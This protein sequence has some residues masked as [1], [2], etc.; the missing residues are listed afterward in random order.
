[1]IAFAFGPYELD[2]D[3]KELRRDGEP[4]PL[5]SRLADVLCALVS[6][7]GQTLTKDQLIQAAWRDVAV[8][9]NSLEQAISSLRRLLGSAAPHQYIDTQARR[10]YRFVAPVTRIE[11]R[12]SDAALE[13]LLA[14]HRAWM[15]GRAALESLERRE[16]VRARAVF[17]DVVAAAP[18]QAPAHVGLANA[19]AMQF[20]MTRAESAPDF[21]A[22]TLAV[23]HAKEA[24]RLDAG[25]GE[26]WATLGFVLERT[27]ERVDALA[28]LRR[29]VSLEPDNWRHQV[30]LAYGSWGEERLRA[31]RRAL[32][33]VPGLAMAHW[34]AATVHVAR[35]ALVDAERDLRAGLE[36]QQQA[37]GPFSAVALHWLAGLLRLRE[38]AHEAAL[39]Q[40]DRE[41]A[42]ETS[43]HLYA[44][45]CCANTWYAIGALHLRCRRNTDAAS[46]FRQAIARVPLHPG[47]RVG[48]AFSEGTTAVRD[49][50]GPASSSIEAV[51]AKAAALNLRGDGDRAAVLVERELEQAPPGN[52]GWLLP[53][54]PLLNV[55]AHPARW[56]RALARLRVRS[57]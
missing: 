27:G 52:T 9:D 25:Y 35:Q 33:L 40:F 32:A 50:G 26:A 46:A 12:A 8:T 55:V 4:V 36:A 3:R 56:S 30:R 41:L 6:R 43:G 17:A 53:V 44:R 7:A 5:N 31:A 15:E 34:L 24:C 14:P 19:C 51:L 37:A 48:L 39:D 10:G 11:R 23:E 57:V 18:A 1:V 45:E 20:E 49:R 42:S 2:A 22:L 28:A 29:A 21:A 13:A 38:D 54:E 16:I 47:A